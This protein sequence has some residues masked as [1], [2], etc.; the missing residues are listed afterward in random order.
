MNLKKYDK[1]KSVPC[2]SFILSKK[3]TASV[4]EWPFSGSHAQGGAGL[5]R[6]EPSVLS[7]TS[8]Y[9]VVIAQLI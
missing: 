8:P 7:L 9:T 3:G 4:G 6:L 5:E 2:D 1:Q